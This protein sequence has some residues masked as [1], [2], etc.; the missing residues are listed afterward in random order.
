MLP[1]KKNVDP[2]TT[3]TKD[4]TRN[5][6]GKA[7]SVTPFLKVAAFFRMVELRNVNTLNRVTTKVNG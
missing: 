7:G 3:S 2:P 1:G 5:M 4:V 6:I